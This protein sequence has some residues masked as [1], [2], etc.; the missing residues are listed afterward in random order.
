MFNKFDNIIRPYISE[1]LTN[2]TFVAYNTYVPTINIIVVTAE[3]IWYNY[4][5]KVLKTLLFLTVL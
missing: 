2:T 4:D 1:L 3:F 5:T